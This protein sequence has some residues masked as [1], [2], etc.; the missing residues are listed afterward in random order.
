MFELVRRVISHL[1]Y[2]RKRKSRKETVTSSK[3]HTKNFITSIFRLSVFAY[4]SI[5]GINI[6]N[7]LT[8]NLKKIIIV[9]YCYWYQTREFG[10]YRKY[11]QK[12]IFN[13]SATQI[14]Y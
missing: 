6:N 4:E 13:L 12:N 11:L 2:K 8:F 3:T 7:L 9:L 5:L 1:C 14:N 10:E